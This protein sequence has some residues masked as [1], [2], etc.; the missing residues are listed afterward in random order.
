MNRLLA[1]LFLIAIPLVAKADNS[2]T[3]PPL[4]KGVSSFGAVVVGDYLYV[5]GGHTGKAHSY[6]SE[7]TSGEFQRLNL[8]KP[9]KWE[10][11]PGGIGVQGLALVSHGD[12]IY[13]IGGLQAL[14]KKTEKT[15][16]RSVASVS[17]FDTKTGKWSDGEAL[18]ET[19]SSHD[20]VVVGDKIYV[21]GGW[22]LNGGSTGGRSV[23]VSHGLVLNLS[24]PGAKWE[25]LKQPFQ[26]RALTMAAY[27]GKVWVIGGL[28][29]KASDPKVD[30]FD[31]KTASWSSAPTVPGDSL[32]AF[33]AAA[34][35]LDGKLYLTAKDGKLYRLAEK[36][37]G[38]EEVGEYKNAR[39]VAR[40]VNF[41][42]NLVVIAGATL[43]G[44]QATLESVLPA[45]VG[46][47]VKTT[48][49][50]EAD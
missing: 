15:D 35:V 28:G 23:W 44:N 16:I 8:A 31:P 5:Y 30:I 2:S 47:S 1:A 45:T 12:K 4:A 19:R 32:N 11:L 38:W 41:D 34:A 10:Q 48:T 36:N 50:K 21:F 46:K 9:E 40:L 39:Y 6:S 20:A 29:E 24:Q 14:N 33:S 17:I 3:Y 18:P 26:R 49:N 22:Q 42:K 37:S 27:D 43:L 7:T 25:T 13:R